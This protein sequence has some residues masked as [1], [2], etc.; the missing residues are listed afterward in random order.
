[1]INSQN[2]R[3][4]QVVIKHVKFVRIEGGAGATARVSPVLPSLAYAR[5]QWFAVRA[6]L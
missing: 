6:G 1:M 5:T 3:E 4:L 2:L